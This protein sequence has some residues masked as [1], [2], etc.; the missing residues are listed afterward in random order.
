MGTFSRAQARI[1]NVSLFT[2]RHHRR[3]IS[4]QN[5]FFMWNGDSFVAKWYKALWDA[6]DGSIRSFADGAKKA[7]RMLRL[8]RFLVALVVLTILG[9]GVA[10]IIWPQHMPY[11]AAAAM[12]FIAIPYIVIYVLLTL[13]FKA[14]SVVR[15]I[16]MGYPA[17]AK[18]L[19]IR[20]AARKM[21]EESIETEELLVATAWNESKKMLKQYRARQ[22]AKRAAADD[23]LEEEE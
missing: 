17:N 5:P 13:P 3:G 20:F 14:K 1:L 22:A 2:T 8:A 11:F 18:E 23:E 9:L 6:I 4:N 15:L 10:G 19:A 7:L 12:V 21:H 16:D